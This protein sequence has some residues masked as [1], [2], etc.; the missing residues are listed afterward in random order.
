M[1]LTWTVGEGAKRVC[2][3]AE[4]VPPPRH[5][6]L[7]AALLRFGGAGVNSQLF[8]VRVAH[9]FG[10]GPLMPVSATCSP[11]A[12]GKGWALLLHFLHEEKEKKR[13]NATPQVANKQEGVLL[14][15]AASS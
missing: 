6:K 14:R 1:F 2:A 10:A 5:P 7:A 9:L 3:C 4:R 13:D 11:L 15:N 8:K 12:A